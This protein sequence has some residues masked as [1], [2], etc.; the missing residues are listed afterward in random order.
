MYRPT[1]RVLTVLELLQ[2]HQRM[3]GA[4]LARRLEVSVRT[5]RRYVEILQDL[6]I[7]VEA[8]RGRYGAYGLRPGFK[9]PP[10]MLSEDE[11]LAVTLGLLAVRGLGLGV[12]APAV[13]IALAKLDRVLPLTL[14]D[15]VEAVQEVLVLHLGVPQVRPMS[16]TVLAFSTAASEAQQVKIRYRSWSGEETE[17]AIDPYGVVYHSGIWYVTGYCHLR[18]GPRIFRLDR[19][20]SA[21]VCDEAGSFVLQES[22]DS[23]DFVLRSLANTPYSLPVLVTLAMTLEEARRHI[24][25]SL[26]TLE[27]TSEGVL[28][29]CFTDNP[30][31]MAA[32]L[33]GLECDFVVHE[34]PEVREALKHLAGR[35][36]RMADADVA[37]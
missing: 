32:V 12:A 35:L 5:A 19:V 18:D 29:R 13:E 17:R 37:V 34:P 15:R 21:E 33:A 7:P 14:R 22:F 8:E 28:M 20:L 3:T 31:W 25:E 16:A 9:L 27:E 26:A 2:S 36:L 30:N 4:E 10:L 24:P 11:A 6:G 1:T 23:L